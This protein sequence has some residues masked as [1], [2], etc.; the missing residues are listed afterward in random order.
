MNTHVPPRGAASSR[1]GQAGRSSASSSR[2]PARSRSPPPPSLPLISPWWL[3]L[4]AFVGINQL[5]FVVV[6]R[7]RRLARPASAC[8]VVESGC[9]R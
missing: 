2:W 1:H 3:L 8:S 9:A 4:A 5:A 7:L 6:R